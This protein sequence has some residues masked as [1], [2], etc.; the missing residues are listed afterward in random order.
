M[1]A[2]GQLGNGTMPISPSAMTMTTLQGRCHRTAAVGLVG[3]R[4]AIAA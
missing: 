3:R 4:A 1:G 2:S